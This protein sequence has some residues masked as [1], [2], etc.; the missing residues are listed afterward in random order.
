[1][2]TCRGLDV[3]AYQ[4]AQDWQAHKQQGVAF[5]FAKASEGERSRDDM[6]DTHIAAILKAGLTTGAYHFGW[7]VQN[8]QLEAANYVAAVAPYAHAHPLV[9][10]LDLERY[11]DGRNY[12]GR[13]AAQIH[14]WVTTWLAAVQAAFPSQRVGVYTSADDIAAGHLPAGAPLWYPRYPGASVDTYAEAEQAPRPAP[15]GRTVTFWQFTS[16]PLDR[17]L[18]YMSATDLQAWAAGTRT[19]VYEPYP[20]RAFFL[21]GTAPAIGKTSPIFAAMGRRLVEVG[22]GR[23]RVGPGPEL[24]WADVDSYE[25]WQ[26]QYSRIHHKGWTGSSLLWPPGPETWDAL[27][28]PKS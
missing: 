23:Y 22:C 18:C 16:T 10:W 1:M 2:A 9:H 6:F 8:P 17:S 27:K 4:P 14:D 7:P 24:G 3:S 12:R 11:N 13:T 28:V 19:P 20:G 21:H 26:R 5:A 15:S 25:A